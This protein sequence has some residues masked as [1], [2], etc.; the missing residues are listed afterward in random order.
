[1]VCEDR[2]R[3][4]PVLMIASIVWL[5]GCSIFG[6]GQPSSPISSQNTAAPGADSANPPATGQPNATAT[7]E[8]PRGPLP[9]DPGP[10]WLQNPFAR[11]PPGQNGEQVVVQT[12]PGAT[13]ANPPGSAES[14][15][16]S[17]L[18]NNARPGWLQGVFG[19]PLAV[20]EDP[21][22]PKTPVGTVSVRCPDVEIREGTETLRTFRVGAGSAPEALVW[23]ATFG[24]LARE[25][26]TLGVE[27]NYSGFYKVGASGR[28]L[29]GPA[30]V[31][32]TYQVPVRVALVRGGTDVLDSRLTQVSII[33]AP[34]DAQA[35][36]T[37][38]VDNFKVKRDKTDNLSDLQIY[39]GFDPAP[40]APEKPA[41]KSRARS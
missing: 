26:R 37:V 14:S 1:M 34:G 17:A 21:N 25:C 15:A 9:I 5:G 11:N 20:P 38:V 30:G 31:P 22:K 33:V 39:V 12:A 32:G 28:I 6:G 7:A 29:L 16:A 27:D 2:K 3:L 35:S 4:Q 10:G 23:Q 41:R 18:P 40:V 8:P 19:A 36:F 13:N 24:K